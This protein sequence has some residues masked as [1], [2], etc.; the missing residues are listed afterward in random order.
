VNKPIPAASS[1]VL[2]SN[3]RE[4]ANPGGRHLFFIEETAEF[5]RKSM[6]FLRSLDDG[7]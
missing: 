4:M 5:N 6:E 2:I 7:Q 1:G 3:A